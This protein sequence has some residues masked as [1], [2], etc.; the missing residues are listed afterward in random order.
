MTQSKTKAKPN[1]LF[2]FSDTGG[3]HRSAAEA[4]IEALEL[5]FPDQ[6]TC[7]MVDFFTSYAPPPFNTAASTYAP[8]AQIPDVWEFGYKISNGKMRARIVQKILWP[9]VRKSITRLVEEH[10]C[11]LFI[12]VH[13]VINI[14]LLHGLP[15]DRKPYM[16]VVTDMVSTH[17]FWYSKMSDVMFLPTQEAL[18]RGI[19][20][21]LDPSKMYVVGLPVADRFCRPSKN[22]N[23]IRKKLGWP[24]DMPIAI[25]VSGGEGM[26]PLEETVQAIFE[27]EVPV[28]LVIIAGKNQALKTKLEALDSKYPAFVYGFVTEMSD[29]MQAADIIVTKAGPGTISEA[30]IAGLP[31]IL[32]SRMPGQEDGNVDYVVNHGAGVWAPGPQEVVATLTQWVDDPDARKKVAETSKSL[33][34]PQASRQIAR[35]AMAMLGK[36]DYKKVGLTE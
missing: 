24:S 34:K 17:A 3:G 23:T 29:F 8:M 4:I 30:F 13:S 20:I 16:T 10:P 22:R 15:K 28:C 35:Y 11:D 32:Y 21:G 2:L 7:E 26:G 1:I 18:Q 9:Y 27:A 33:A 5:E 25:M 19:T 31:I 12:S 36:L 14:P 6:C